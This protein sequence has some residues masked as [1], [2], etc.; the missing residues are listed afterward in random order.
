MDTRTD[1]TVL[2]LLVLAVVK[3]RRLLHTQRL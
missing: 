2:R 3:G 1:V